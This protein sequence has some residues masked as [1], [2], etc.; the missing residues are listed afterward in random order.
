MEIVWKD[1]GLRIIYAIIGL[2]IYS[3]LKIKD[4]IKVFNFGI[5]F[6]EN[7]GFWIWAMLLQLIFAFLLTIEPNAAEAIKAMTGLDYSE[8]MAFVTSG[9]GLAALANAASNDKIG[10][11]TK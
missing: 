7:K 6:K 9:A 4:K 1:L 2:L 10:V 11:K 8:T 5:F 3:L